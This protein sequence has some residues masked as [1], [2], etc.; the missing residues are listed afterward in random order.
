MTRQIPP[1]IILMDKRAIDNRHALEHVL[2]A[3]AQIMAVPQIGVLVEHDVDLDVQLV[4]G[5]VGLQVLDLGDGLGEAHGEVEEDV[6]LVGRGGG[7]RQVA[8]VRRAGARPI[9]DDE[10]REQQAAEGVE[11]PDLRVVADWTGAVSEMLFLMFVV[12]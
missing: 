8:D 2:E 4:A 3:L 12:L 1:R 5:V 7:A 9:G 11:P 6:A 10:E